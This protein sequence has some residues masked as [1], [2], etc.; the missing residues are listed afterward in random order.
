MITTGPQTDPGAVGNP[1]FSSTADEE[2]FNVTLGTL[3]NTSVCSS[4]APGPGSVNSSYNNYTT[5]VAAP[6]LT[7]GQT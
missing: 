3:N 5:S 2:I 6:V 7:A 1:T 4:V